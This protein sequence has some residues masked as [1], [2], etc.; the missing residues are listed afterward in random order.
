[1][2]RTRIGVTYLPVLT[3]FEQIARSGRNGVGLWAP[4]PDDTTKQEEAQEF[5]RDQQIIRERAEKRQSIMVDGAVR[6]IGV[7]YLSSSTDTI[8]VG[9][10]KVWPRRSRKYLFP[11]R[12][13][14]PATYYPR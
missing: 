10:S 9:C 1:M 5:E 4:V 8:F 13:T 3:Y 2:R 7:L 14:T 11:S 6:Y 12:P